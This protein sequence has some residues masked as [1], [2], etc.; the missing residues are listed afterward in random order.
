MNVLLTISSSSFQDKQVSCFCPGGTLVFFRLLL[1]F[2]NLKFFLFYVLVFSSCGFWG[3]AVSGYLW[4]GP[5][6]DLLKGSRALKMPF[7]RPCALAIKGPGLPGLLAGASGRER[8]LGGTLLGRSRSR[9][10]RRSVAVRKRKRALAGGESGTV[11]VNP[12][13]RCGNV[14]SK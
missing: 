13:A 14:H 1:V 11:P 9:R 8:S 7:K 3:S 4:G 5:L 10:K 6:K 12:V 2:I